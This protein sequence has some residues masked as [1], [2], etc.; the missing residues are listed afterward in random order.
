MAPSTPQTLF[1]NTDK[2][3]IDKM[4]KELTHLVSDEQ[5]EVPT[6]KDEGTITESSMKR[7]LEERDKLWLRAME[8]AQLK[9]PRITK[10]CRIF[11]NSI[12]EIY[13]KK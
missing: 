9:G 11:N 10:I 6:K 7:V 12:T 3:V 1:A 4:E 2:K 8:K 5:Q 13:G